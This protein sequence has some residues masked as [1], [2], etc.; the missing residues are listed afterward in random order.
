MTKREKNPAGF[1]PLQTTAPPVGEEGLFP[2]SLRHLWPPSAAVVGG[3]AGGW[4]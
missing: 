3:I 2:Q 1:H 4:V